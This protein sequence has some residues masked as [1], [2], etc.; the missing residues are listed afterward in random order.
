MNKGDEAKPDLRS[1][2][3]GKEF[4]DSIDPSLYAATPPIE[5]MRL[6]LSRA[7]TAVPNGKDKIVMT[8]DVRRAYFHAAITREVY[9]EIPKEDKSIED[10]D[11][12][13]RL[14]L[15]LYGTR[16][17]AH[18]WQ[19]T[20]SEHL[21]SIGF[22]KG[23]AHPAVFH[24]QKRDII[25]L[26]HGDDYMSC[27]SPEDMAW[28]RDQLE[29]RFEIK[30]QLIGHDKNVPQEGKI[31][32]RVVRATPQGFEM[33]ADPRHSELIV[34]ALDI[35]GARNAA[36][37][38]VDE[39][40]TED[41]P[42]S[43]DQFFQYRSLTARANYLAIDRP[44]ILFAT[45]ELCR[46]MSN[47]TQQ[48]W[49]RLIRLGRYLRGRPRLVWHFNWQEEP[50]ELRMF[51]DANWAGCPRSR[52]STS[53]GAALL[54]IHPIRVY[55]KTQS[56]IALSSAESE[57]YATCKAATE[58]IGVLSLMKD[59]GIEKKIVMEVDASA[60]LGVIE[61]KGIGRIRHLHTNAL[62]IQEQQIRN[63]IRFRK[64]P[65]ADNV[66]DLFTKN[67]SRDTCEKH[68]R[69]LGCQFEE[70]RAECAAQLHRIEKLM[71]EVTSNNDAIPHDEMN[72]E[73]TEGWSIE[74]LTVH[75]ERHQNQ[76]FEQFVNQWSSDI[77]LDVISSKAGIGCTKCMACGDPSG[78]TD[79]WNAPTPIQNMWVRHHLR[80]RKSKFTPSKSKGGPSD[81]STLSPI[82]ITIGKYDDDGKAFIF[83]DRWSDKAR[84]HEELD[85]GWTGF[86]VFTNEC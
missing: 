70:G 2:L 64:T 68:V 23:E 32:N 52:K 80:P 38:G 53:G 50:L 34:E 36:T 67:T 10:G 11:V 69:G 1:R 20:V 44:D 24:H 75:A 15:C 43:P 33:E 22:N 47:P 46:K 51:S 48:A 45:K 29:A 78:L 26:V 9:I 25:T 49:Q 85:K 72:W 81:M 76:K 84:A 17:A 31:L 7:A 18:R 61:R 30:T 77:A 19:Q 3:V 82:R 62:W 59:L 27:G 57:F 41:D 14:K 13:G 5:A 55:S 8:N 4:A 58:G 63:V 71:S 65:G 56:V 21:E 39:P 35:K 37:A 12:V 66:A 83:K 60:A 54:G 74:D 16:D 6:I 40:D 73:N 42:L 86:T 28:L 79:H